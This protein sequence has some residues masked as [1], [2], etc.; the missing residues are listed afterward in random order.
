[1]FAAVAGKAVGL[2]AS[3]L[4]GAVAYDGVKRVARSGAVREAAVTATTWGLRGARA[5]E[6]GAEK[7]RLTTADI[8]SEARGRIGEQTPAPGAGDGHG[9]GHEH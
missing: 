6:T 1:M 7:A 9:H 5:A 4:A 8:V 3:G 2:V